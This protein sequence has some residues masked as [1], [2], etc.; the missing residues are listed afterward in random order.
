MSE[1]RIRKKSGRSTVA[2]TVGKIEEALRCAANPAQAAILRRFFKTGPGQY[3]EGDIFIGLKVPVIRGVVKQFGYVPPREALTL[4]RS[5]IHEMRLAGLLLWVKAFEEGD[6]RTRRLVFRLYLQ[7]TRHINNWD[8]VDLSAPNI[9]GA[10][11]KPEDDPSA[12]LLQELAGSGW[13]WDRRIAVVATFAF[14]RQGRFEP[15]LALCRRLLKD[16]HDLMHKA[17]GWMLREVGKRDRGTLRA[18]LDV[19]AGQMPRT[20]LRYALEHFGPAERAK[21]MR[22]G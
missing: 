20:M 3:G 13:L 10:F 11:L 8:L 6:E 18:F 7:N 16:S 14:I 2:T 19:H 1:L 15:T 5:P 9:V 17:C 12:A 4:V 21:Y 22:R